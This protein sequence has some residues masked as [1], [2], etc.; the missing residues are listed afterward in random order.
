MNKKYETRIVEIAEEEVE[1]FAKKDWK[2]NPYLWETETDVHAELYNRIKEALKR[3]NKHLLRAK[4]EGF[5]KPEKFNRIYCK[6]P[7]YICWEGIKKSKCF[8]D[9]V[10]YKDIPNINKPPDYD[11]KKKVNWPMLWVC[12]IKYKTDWSGDYQKCNRQRDNKKLNILL[13]QRNK[14]KINGT[15]YGCCLDFSR[16]KNRENK[17]YKRKFK[18]NKSYLDPDK[19]FIRRYEFLIQY[20]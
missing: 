9:I 19:R 4:Y 7:V 12:E 1:K 17:G 16:E 2:K 8:P 13:N 15:D 3:M 14:K 20:Q 18:P 11:E 10:I 5:K 6:P